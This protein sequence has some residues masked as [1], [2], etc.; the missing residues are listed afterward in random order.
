MWMYINRL[1]AGPSEVQRIYGVWMRKKYVGKTETHW[2][3]EFQTEGLAQIQFIQVQYWYSTY[4]QETRI[5]CIGI[6]MK[7]HIPSILVASVKSLQCNVA[8]QC[9]IVA[10]SSWVEGSPQFTAI[11]SQA[12]DAITRTDNDRNSC[13][14]L[15]LW[16]DFL[17]PELM[18]VL[19]A[20]TGTHAHT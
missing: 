1:W 15:K 6:L 19:G 9:S 12:L 2:G 14:S 11:K 20:I 3:N 7:T 8:E 17:T 5:L 13:W 10:V 4:K 18:T 16:F